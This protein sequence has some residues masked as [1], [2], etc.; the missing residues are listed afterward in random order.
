MTRWDVLGDGDGDGEHGPE[1]RRGG[2][3]LCA[4][5]GSVRCGGV[6]VGMRMRMRMR[7]MPGLGRGMGSGQR[8]LGGECTSFCHAAR[9]SDAPV[10]GRDGAYRGVW[11]ADLVESGGVGERE[12]AGRFAG[13]GGHERAEEISVVAREEVSSLGVEMACSEWRWCSPAMLRLRGSSG[14]VG[15]VQG[16]KEVLGRWSAR[17]EAEDSVVAGRRSQTCSG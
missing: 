15:V 6:G 3:G 16:T 11:A 10:N 14:D 12:R 4:G 17:V 2:F 9:E 5:V 13:D 7:R 1:E 8:F